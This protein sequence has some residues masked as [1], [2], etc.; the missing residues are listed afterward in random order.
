MSLFQPTPCT[1]CPTWNCWRPMAKPDD[2][3]WKR[4]SRATRIG[5]GWRGSRRKCLSAAPAGSLS[6]TW[7]STS[8]R[9]R[10]VLRTRARPRAPL[11]TTA[12]PNL[13]RCCFDAARFLPASPRTKNLRQGIA[14]GFGGLALS[15]FCLLRDLTGR[16][17]SPTWA[18]FIFEN[19]MSKS[20]FSSRLLCCNARPRRCS[21]SFD[22]QA[23]SINEKPRQFPAGVS[24]RSIRRSRSEVT[25]GAHL[26]QH[27]ILILELV[28]GRRLRRT[29]TKD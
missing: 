27:R 8:R 28:G 1:R 5:R 17:A 19:Y 26:Q 7:P 20:C 23:R 21:R 18:L 2:N 9:R 3:S 16:H 10:N 6:A 14:G 13:E 29:R 15:R 24:S 12:F 11:R 25:L 4:S 22:D